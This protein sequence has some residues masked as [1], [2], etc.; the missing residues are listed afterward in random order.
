MASSGTSTQPGRMQQLI[1][2]DRRI[3]TA[4]D[5]SAMMKQIQATHAPDGR[6]VEVK[7]ILSIIEDIIQRA[8]STIDGVINGT[9]AHAEHA[10]EDKGSVAETES[11]LEALAFII[12]RISC[13]MSCKCSG[14]GDAHATTMVLFNTLSSYSWD[15]KVVLALAAFAVNFGEFWLVA[16]LSTTNPLARS[17]AR[18][19]QL[20]DILEH[21]T[22]LKSRLDALNNL[23]QATMNVT[24]CIIEFKEL[25]SQYISPEMP[26]MSVAVAHIPTAAYWTIRSIVACAS[27]ITSLI[28]S[29]HE[30]ITS[31]TETWELSSL[32][33]KVS[34]IHDHLKN[35]LALCHQH[36]A[37][38][39]QV[40][41]Y[42]ILLR[43]IETPHLD[44]SKI[45][46]QLIYN[47]DDLL[48]LV[49]G[50]NKTRVHVEVLRR[51][52]VVLLISDLDLSFEE[53]TILDQIYKES[54]TRTEFQYD[55]V[56]LPVVDR[57]TPWS[58]THEKKF[59]EQ[60]AT[61]SWYTLHH[62][63]LLE[64]AV[65]KYIKEVWRFSKKLILVVLDLQGKV[66]SL[67]ALHMMWIWGNLAYPFTTMKEEA[68]WKEETWRLELLVDGIDPNIPNW[69]EEKKFVCLY[70]GEDMDWI[71]KFTAM[72]KDV[73]KEAG[74]S[75]EMVYV[76]K[77]NTKERLRKIIATISTEHL[78]HTWPDLTSIW[79]F[80][81]RLESMLYSKMSH[82]KAIDNDLIM[83]EVMTM[84]SFDGSDLGW[85]VISGESAE[86]TKA[87]GD[88]LLTCLSQFNEW[89]KD[90][91]EKGFVPALNDHLHHLHSPL[92]CNRLILP[93]IDGSISEKVICAECG[94]PME[95]YFM[96]RCCND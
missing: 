84:L 36:I 79:F 22:S 27:Q 21:S 12:F 30:Y 8:R 61:M 7:P 5:D 89:K 67:N 62:P 80:W 20:P 57:S 29:G 60:Q 71:R 77:S 59:R 58:E 42:Q 46:R 81:A 43:L 3:F 15:A 76:G 92:H 75:L 4:S 14:G 66:V 91:E 1:K 64:P 45:L 18:L 95:K 73:A 13:E 11:L 82:G 16:H 41:A 25:P 88:T 72:A 87:K 38:K 94:R 56:W 6:E 47:K 10:L 86:I 35:Q 54:K 19:K 65:I 85:A 93:G 17:V 78:S 96:Y 63:T 55:I 31:T 68:L 9:Q 70:G 90:A 44:N 26:P 39:R 83:Q 32:G 40:E 50:S 24:K 51:K 52:N 33:H 37:E 49:D 53:L 48:P 23:V 2:S 69:I 34:N 74:I 28:G